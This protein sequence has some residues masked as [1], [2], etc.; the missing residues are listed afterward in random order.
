MDKNA[1]EEFA[2]AIRNIFVSANATHILL[3]ALL[4]THPDKKALLEAIKT[5]R[6]ASADMSL[7]MSVDDSV[8]AD[9]DAFIDSYV[10]VLTA[11]R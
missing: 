9:V 4:A 1:E 11:L 5:T 7:T 8:L 3:M 10:E 6:Q 2:A